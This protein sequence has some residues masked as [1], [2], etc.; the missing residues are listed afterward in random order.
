[1]KIKAL[2]CQKCGDTIW[3]RHCHD[4]RWCKCGETAVDGGREYMKASF[5]T[6][7]PAVIEIEVDQ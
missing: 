6:V 1:M 5:K 2:V 4:F 7:P 3:S